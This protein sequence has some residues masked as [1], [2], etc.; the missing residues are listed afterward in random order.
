MGGRSGR[1]T[2]RQI[3]V[4]RWPEITLFFLLLALA[5]FSP[6][7]LLGWRWWFAVWLAGLAA[8]TVKAVHAAVVGRELGSR[9]AILVALS[10]IL[11]INGL[12][13]MT[14]GIRSPWWPAYLVLMAVVAARFER[15][16][17]QALFVAAISGL[18]GWQIIWRSAPETLATEFSRLGVGAALILS[19]L[20]AVRVLYGREQWRLRETLEEH[21][22]LRSEAEELELMEEYRREPEPESIS[23][24]GRETRWMS[25]VVDLKR[26]LGR[27]L[28]LA[29]R[30]LGAQT[31]ALFQLR[32]A[33]DRLTLWHAAI[34][35]P[36]VNP[37][38]DI[39]NGEG[40]IGGVAKIRGPVLLTDLE[41]GDVRTGYYLEEPRVR[42]L[43]AV[44]VNEESVLRGVLVADSPEAE[45]FGKAEQELLEGFSQEVTVILENQRVKLR[46][47]KKSEQ[48]DTLR[49]L[50]DALSSTLKVDVM[51]NKMVEL[52]GEVLPFEHCA[53]FLTDPERRRLVL[54]VQRGDLFEEKKEVTLALDQGLIGRIASQRNPFIFS[55]LQE[56]KRKTELVPGYRCRVRVR[57]F[58]GVPIPLEDEQVG[59]YF[60]TSTKPRCFDSRDQETLTLLANQAAVLISNAF[61]HQ[62]VEKMAVTDG[63]TGLNNHRH[64]QERLTDELE[65][66]NRHGEPLTLLILDIDHFKKINDS[67]G[68]PFGDK[69]L[70]TIAQHLFRLTRKNDYVARNGGEEFAII[71]V[72]TDRR[73]CRTMAQRILKTIR[74]MKFSHEGILFPVGV[75]IG[76]AVFPDDGR[77]RE[78]LIQ[79]ADQ[80]L[81]Y[82]KESGRDQYKAYHDI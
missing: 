12:G 46:R 32:E 69:V 58:V 65:R 62:R 42:S 1:V 37:E 49:L 5:F 20:V 40:V 63:L 9:P 47:E 54:R 30:A 61:L 10:V 75:S 7:S 23:P 57:S 71:M 28:N 11:F 33:R 8:V 14:G 79:R 70:H 82:A 80:A 64:F 21:R 22:R 16:W 13:S 74:S 15:W 72:N 36:A 38:I 60:L 4:R 51:L 34:S 18:E 19:L 81:Y 43:I 17:H 25:N 2:L 53:V 45:A 26:D 77:T 39:R 3:V 67:Y 6:L 78:E 41:P 48:R 73:G 68:H 52:T 55:D 56:R 44:P 50:S 35:G 29:R 66:T 24:K 31:V 59:V 76:A 27:L